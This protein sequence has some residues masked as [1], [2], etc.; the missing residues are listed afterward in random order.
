[1]ERNG[2]GVRVDGG[3]LLDGKG[4][5]GVEVEGREDVG[6][7][8]GSGGGGGGERERERLFPLVMLVR[9]DDV[10]VA[11]GREPDMRGCGEAREQVK[12]LVFV[13]SSPPS[14]RLV[15]VIA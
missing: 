3:A 14:P 4:R 9:V 12:H 2:S 1:M 8:R 5:E 10:V 15:Q 7:N 6:G 11:M 13:L